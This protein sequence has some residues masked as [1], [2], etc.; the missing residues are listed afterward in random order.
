MPDKRIKDFVNTALKMGTSLTNAWFAIDKESPDRTERINAETLFSLDETK[1]PF[2]GQNYIFVNSKGTPEENYTALRSAI[3]AA[4]SLTPNGNALSATNRARVMFFNMVAAPGGS[5][6][7]LAPAKFVDIIGIGNREANIIEATS[8]LATIKLADDNDNIIESVIINNTGGGESIGHNVGAQDN[9]IIRNCILGAKTTENTVWAGLYKNI[10]C[11]AAGVLNGNID[12]IVEDCDFVAN[13]CGSSTT[14]NVSISGK[15]SRC[16]AQGSVCFGA[17]AGTG[18]NVSIYGIIE[19]IVSSSRSLGSASGSLLIDSG[20]I[21][22]RCNKNNP[23]SQ[24]LAHSLLGASNV[25]VSGIIE[26]CDSYNESIGNTSSTGEIIRCKR[27]SDYGVHSGFIKNCDFIG[28]LTISEGATV[29]RCDI[30]QGKI[31]ATTNIS[32]K[33]YLNSLDQNY[34]TVHITNLI[35]TPYNV[36][37]T[38]I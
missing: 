10:K 14:Q 26:D 23:Q 7:P 11:T 18:L 4:N 36:I 20:A 28:N 8:S 17:T 1:I 19:D 31:I 30:D 21:I 27:S 15:I 35:A 5:T 3:I 38:N 29:R 24:T 6:V 25:E 2:I 16:Y 34:D 33:I 13:S 9:S 12:G 37:D 32:A 22:R